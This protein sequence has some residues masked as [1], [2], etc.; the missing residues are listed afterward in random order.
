MSDKQIP[1]SLIITINKYPQLGEI[2]LFGYELFVESK[3][4]QPELDLT[5]LK[6]TPEL[7]NIKLKEGF[8]LLKKSEITVPSN[9]FKDVFQRIS[10][11]VAEKRKH[12][13]STILEL[14]KKVE[15]REINIQK[16]ALSALKRDT[17]TIEELN[18]KEKSRS[19]VDFL[20]RTSLK[21]FG[22][23][24]GIALNSYLPSR[25]AI[26]S[27]SY[28]PICGSHPL[29]AYIEGEEGRRNLICSWCDTSWVYPRIKCPYCQNIDQKDLSYFSLNDEKEKNE[30]DRVAVCEKC[31][32]YIKTL[33]ARKWE[34][35]K[36]I[37]FQIDD[38]ATIYLDLLAEREG[39]ERMIRPFL[40]L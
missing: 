40:S 29:L 17:D 36:A 1:E 9:Q 5:L 8:P 26:W 18:D 14:L 11:I 12:L 3:K 23:A 10:L 35:K 7:V 34:G 25:E 31:R 13:Q 21:P 33:Y 28:C 22:Q 30:E 2:V 24:Y 6:F 27:Q 16:L 4:I 32:K 37:D 19:I 38:L 20:I 15:N 39:Y